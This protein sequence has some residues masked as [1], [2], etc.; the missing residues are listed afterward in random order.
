MKITSIDNC[1]EDDGLANVYASLGSL[2]LFDRGGPKTFIIAILPE[3]D[4]TGRLNR[5][6]ICTGDSVCPNDQTPPADRALMEAIP[7][8]ISDLQSARAAAYAKESEPTVQ[9]I[10]K[11]E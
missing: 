8:I 4:E 3:Y 10:L 7:P 6:N 2:V 1:Y 5:L 9:P 11:K